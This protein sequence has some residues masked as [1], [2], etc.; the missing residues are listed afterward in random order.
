MSK[1]TE[2]HLRAAKKHDGLIMPIHLRDHETGKTLYDNRDA[3]AMAIKSIKDFKART[4]YTQDEKEAYIWNVLM[5]D[6]ICKC[7]TKNH[8]YLHTKYFSEDYRCSSCWE[9][10]K[11]AEIQSD[12][13]EEIVEKINEMFTLDEFQDV[14]GKKEKVEWEKKL[15]SIISNATTTEV[16][17]GISDARAVS[18]IYPGL[19]GIEFNDTTPRL[20]LVDQIINRPD[21]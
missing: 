9:Y 10:I 1:F 13:F 12:K 4:D 19:S 3:T 20:H 8:V 7:N 18:K 11:P 15:A 16:A 6:H 21:K 17:Y 14:K 5:E 2:H